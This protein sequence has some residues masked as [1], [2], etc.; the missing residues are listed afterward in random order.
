MEADSEFRVVVCE[1]DGRSMVRVNGDVDAASSPT[2]RD[3]LMALL[4]VGEREINVDLTDVSFID[5]TGLGVVIDLLRAGAVITIVGAS[6]H[7]RRL[8]DLTG[9]T[10]LDN[11]HEAFARS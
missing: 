10:T 11:V 5:S 1:V 7:A 9:I 3:A 6:P 4:A 8:I 2:L